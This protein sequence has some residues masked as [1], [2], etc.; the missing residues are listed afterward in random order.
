MFY[1]VFD[2]NKYIDEN[3]DTLWLN[4]K[5]RSD[6]Y[7]EYT[8]RKSTEVR[9]K[10][11]LPQGFV[12]KEDVKVTVA[13][14]APD[15]AGTHIQVNDRLENGNDRVDIVLNSSTPV[16]EV[17]LYGTGNPLMLYYELDKDMPGLKKSGYLSESGWEEKKENYILKNKYDQITENKTVEFYLLENREIVISK[18][19]EAFIFEKTN[20]NFNAL[21]DIYIAY[22]DEDEALVWVEKKDFGTENSV[23]YPYSLN[24]SNIK[25]VK[26]FVWG[27][28]SLVPF[29]KAEKVEILVPMCK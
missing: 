8:A 11:S 24:D 21:C 6:I 29:G 22:Y 28:E 7:K 12:C 16:K 9:C 13:L 23:T 27:K 3:F 5:L 1:V 14:G 2:T 18:K 25:L 19:E 4:E 20:V 15:S 10:L 26:A 17:V